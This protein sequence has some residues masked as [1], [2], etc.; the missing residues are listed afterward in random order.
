[1]TL[2]TIGRTALDG[3]GFGL[4]PGPILL[5][6]SGDRVTMSGTYFPASLSEGIAF[7]Q[8]MSGYGSEPVV[9]LI[10]PAQ[11]G[12]TGFYRPAGFAVTAVPNLTNAQ[13]IW[14][15]TAN[16]ERMP[17]GYGQV[18]V[19]HDWLYTDLG[20]LFGAVAETNTPAVVSAPIDY[21]A[22]Y[23][24]DDDVPFTVGSARWSATATHLVQLNTTTTGIV[25]TVALDTADFY[26]AAPVVEAQYGDSTWH[27]VIGRQMSPFVAV[28]MSNGVIRWTIEEDAAI[29]VEAWD[30]SAWQT[31]SALQIKVQPVTLDPIDMRGFQVIR[32][33]H[34]SV[35]VAGSWRAPVTGESSP[36]LF[37]LRAGAPTVDIHIPIAET[38]TLVPQ[39]IGFGATTGGADDPDNNGWETAA[40][41]GNRLTYATSG[42]GTFPIIG[43]NTSIGCSRADTPGSIVGYTINPYSLDDCLGYSR[44]RVTPTVRFV[45]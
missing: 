40:T 31:A 37:T 5:S 41:N 20:V 18:K 33:D 15:W 38:A 23:R 35:T 30:G 9:P 3:P 32:N 10:G 45:T 21:L 1:M 36:V 39:M 25:E 12:V 34:V 26:T 24:S 2:W 4:E 13:G 44:Y 42:V 27:P 43:V 6:R 19:E 22:A 14:E 16:L 29:T 7:A 17:N 28:R 8:Q 11:F